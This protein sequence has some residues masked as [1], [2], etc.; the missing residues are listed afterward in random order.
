MQL[1]PVY[2]QPK[3]A[4]ISTG[5]EIIKHQEKLDYAKIYDINS[6]TLSNAVKACGC[7]PIHSEIVK[8]DYN[9]LKNAILKFKDAD[10]IIIS[11]EYQQGMR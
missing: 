4:V 5:N 8:D 2:T 9:S 11:V 6:Y 10:I 1:V 3:V 7:I